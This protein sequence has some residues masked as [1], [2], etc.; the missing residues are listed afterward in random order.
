MPPYFST[1]LEGEPLSDALITGAVAILVC[2]I[3]N[4]VQFS[5]QRAESDKNI[6]L[7][8]QKL[9]E[10]SDRVNRHNQV[11]VRT[12]KLEESTALQDAE[13]KRINERLKIVEGQK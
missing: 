1:I 13:L 9:D 3:N 11:V 4:W 8:Q 10:L 12:F 5:K 7:I 6:A 2:I